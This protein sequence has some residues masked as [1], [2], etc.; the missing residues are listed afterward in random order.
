MFNKFIFP[1][2]LSLISLP[3]LSFSNGPVKHKVIIDT[4]CAPDDLRAINLM[5]SSPSTEVLAITSEDGVLE[6]EDGYMKIHALLKEHGHQGIQ[7]SQGI[8][9]KNK[10]PFSR[11]I[12]KEVEWGKELISY[13]EP[14]EIKEFLINAIEKEKGPV[15]FVCMG[16]MTNVANAVLMKS[17]IKQKISRIIWFDQCQPG[18]SWTNYGTNCLSADY[19]LKTQIPIHRIITGENPVEFSEEFLEQIGEIQTPYAQSIYQSHSK[20]TIRKEMAEGNFKLYDDLVALYLYYPELFTTDT[21]IR[22]KQEHVVRLKESAKIKDAYLEQLH[23]Y[24]N[25]QSI[26]YKNFPIDSSLY[27]DDIR[28]MVNE[29]LNKFGLREWRAITLTGEIHNHLE[30]YSLIGAKMGIRA[31]EYFRALPGEIT[32]T[33]FCGQTPPLSC[34]NDGLQVACGTTLG[35]GS[36]KIREKGILPRAKFEYKNRAME[37]KLKTEYYNKT[38]E[39]IK[40][41]SN[42]YSK[43]SPSYWRV[44]RQKSIQYWKNWDRKD[45]FNISKV[46]D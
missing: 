9:S 46:T 30:I 22:E 4:D 43:G 1:V 27:G 39:A 45:I 41:A 36:I 32:I 2:L 23:K 5:L 20:D 26:V 3:L 13:E 17:S 29:T 16:P 8:I 40:K 25:L 44:I 33:T 34:I 37:I 21:I 38:Q 24:N 6:P 15:E 18:V 35:K 11:K 14:L 7:T 19:M 12:A 28:D 31:L 10:A 42:E